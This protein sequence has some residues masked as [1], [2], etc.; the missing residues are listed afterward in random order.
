MPLT[1][2]K[3]GCMIF[4]SSLAQFLPECEKRAAFNLLWGY[5][6]THTGKCMIRMSEALDADDQPGSTDESAALQQRRRSIEAPA[7]SHVLPTFACR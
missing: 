5:A 3:C 6:G 4:E 1:A 7:C 2:G